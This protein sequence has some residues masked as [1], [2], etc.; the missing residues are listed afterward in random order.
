MGAYDDSPAFHHLYQ[1]LE[2][3][4]FRRLESCR[5][6][7]WLDSDSYFVQPLFQGII[8]R[9]NYLKTRCWGGISREDLPA[10]YLA[11]VLHSNWAKLP[12]KKKAIQ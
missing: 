9:C 1:Q 5:N 11:L 3:L 6:Y 7:L 4:E 2:K 12:G 8:M 10:E